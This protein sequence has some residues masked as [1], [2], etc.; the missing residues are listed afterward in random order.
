MKTQHYVPFYC[1][2]CRCSCQ[3][4]KRVHCCHENAT[5]G[6]LYTLA[7]KYFVLLL[8][9]VSNEY[10]ECVYIFLPK[11]FRHANLIFSAPCCIV[12]CVLSVCA[13]FCALS[14]KGHDSR[15]KALNIKCVLIF[16]TFFLKPFSF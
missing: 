5:M 13:M 8:T 7:A 1:C 3:L 12:G 4:Y 6:Y 10:S 2:W 15:E 16:S 9:I 11:I 14:H